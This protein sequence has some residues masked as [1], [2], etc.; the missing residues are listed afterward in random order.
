MRSLRPASRAI[1]RSSSPLKSKL[2]PLSFRR[3]AGG[4][5]YGWYSN[6]KRGLAAKA[7]KATGEAAAALPALPKRCLMGWAAL[8]RLVYKADPLKCPE[9]ALSYYVMQ[10]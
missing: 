2:S 8:I 4:E 1:S 3:G 10:K 9:P 5:V 7:G 6:K